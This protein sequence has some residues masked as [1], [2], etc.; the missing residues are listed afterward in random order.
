MVRRRYV[1]LD[2]MAK[3]LARRL[4]RLVI[5]VRANRG[6]KGTKEYALMQARTILNEHFEKLLDYTYR[7]HVK[8]DLHKRKGVKQL[9]Y[10]DIQQ[11]RLA[12]ETKLEDFRK[13]LND[14]A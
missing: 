13:I 3:R 1:Q 2:L 12:V 9:G 7:S 11:L 14:I 4:H 8:R 6:R 5:Y 10:G